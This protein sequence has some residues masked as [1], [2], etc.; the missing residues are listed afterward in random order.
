MKCYASRY[1]IAT[2]GCVLYAMTAVAEI[3]PKLKMTT[4]IPEGITTPDVVETRIGTLRFFDG[5]PDDATTDKVY[6]HLLFSRGIDAFLNAMPGASAEA[7]RKGWVGQGADNNTVLI[8]EDLMDSRSLFLTGNTES[9]YHLMWLDVKDGPLVIE[10]PPNILGIVNDHWFQYVGDIGN[11]G[12]DQGKGGKFLLIPP[13]YKGEIPAG[14]HVFHTPTFGNLYFW[15]GF[16]D[17]GSTATAVANSK[18]FAKVYR[19]ADAANPPAMKFINVSGKHFNTIHDNDFSFFEEVDKVVQYEPAE[20]F[21]PETLGTLAAVGIVKG[22]PFAPDAKTKA[23]LTESI[24]VANA[25][26]RAIAFRPCHFSP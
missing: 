4:E 22:K 17:N 18:K 11:A 21:H 23:I 9:I 5:F 15:R 1:A 6:E 12:P 10:S 19:L 16:L 2:L 7:L 26:A 13:G 8:M 25:T 24:A 3:P 20:A 14:Y